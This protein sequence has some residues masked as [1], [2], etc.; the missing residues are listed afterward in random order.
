MDPPLALP[1]GTVTAM[2]NLRVYAHAIRE[3]AETSGQGEPDSLL[4]AQLGQEGSSE[5]GAAAGDER[6]D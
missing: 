2:G 1:L 3:G 6:G 4:S 5:G